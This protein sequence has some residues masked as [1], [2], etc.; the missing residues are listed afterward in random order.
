MARIRYI[1]NSDSSFE[2]CAI[3]GLLYSDWMTGNQVLYENALPPVLIG[4]RVGGLFPFLQK[5]R[6]SWMT[7]G[8]VYNYCQ[9]DY[10]VLTQGWKI[11]LLQDCFLNWHSAKHFKFP[12]FFSSIFTNKIKFMV[13][14]NNLL[15][16]ILDFGDQLLWMIIFT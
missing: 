12:K 9:V 11:N 5:I 3:F 6:S 7:D 1:F 8:I 4:L 10:G 13:S 2:R 14:E 16:P 15:S